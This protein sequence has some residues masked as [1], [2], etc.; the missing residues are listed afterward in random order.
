MAAAGFRIPIATQR[1]LTCVPDT[2]FTIL[3]LSDA[4]SATFEHL[5]TSQLAD[6]SAMFGSVYPKQQAGVHLSENEKNLSPLAAYIHRTHAR[7]TYY[8]NPFIKYGLRYNAPGPLV[9]AKST[10]VGEGLLAKNVISTVPGKAGCYADDIRDYA[11]KLLEVKKQFGDGIKVHHNPAPDSPP[12]D[13]IFGILIGLEKEGDAADE[14]HF[15]GFVKKNGIWHFIDNEVGFL[16]EIEE[17]DFMNDFLGAYSQA[18]DKTHIDTI[19]IHYS[20]FPYIPRDDLKVAFRI[21]QTGRIYPPGDIGGA[22]NYDSWKYIETIFLTRDIPAMALFGGAAVGAGAVGG[23]GA[24]VNKNE[25]ITMKRYSR[26]SKKNSQQRRTPNKTRR[27][28]RS[29]N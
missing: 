5:K 15:M 25:N 29:K 6:A 22:E 12:I 2:F 28:R 19:D 26:K 7:N 23:A 9:R 13:T 16:H 4:T 14:K 10:N 8:S 21:N 11:V 27:H 3:Q 20:N 18:G 17:Q 24:D 1:G